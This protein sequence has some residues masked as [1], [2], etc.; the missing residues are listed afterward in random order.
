MRVIL[1]LCML[2]AALMAQEPQ[3]TNSGELVLPAHYREWVFLSSGL[4]MTYQP[5]TAANQDRS[6]SFTNVFVNPAAYR[7]FLET[8]KWPDQ[9]VLVLEVRFSETKGS[10]N[11]DGHY[12]AGLDHVAVEVKDTARF[13]ASG[14]AFFALGKASSGKL[15]P[16]TADCYSCHAEHGAVDNT[17]VQFYPTLLAVARQ[18]G[19]LRP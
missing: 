11:K 17:F 8:G 1:A 13:P 4:G 16:R 10:I 5:S 18:K 3:F 2:A 14:W 19:T 15:I 9:T 12:Q 7:S 6:P